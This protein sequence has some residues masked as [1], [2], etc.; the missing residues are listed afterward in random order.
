[1]VILDTTI[2]G[3]Q[4]FRMIDPNIILN[5]LYGYP[6]TIIN[7][8]NLQDLNKFN[9]DKLFC[10]VSIVQNENLVKLISQL[11]NKG[12]KII[13][14]VDDYWE[15]PISHYL[16]RY[17]KQNNLIEKTLSFIQA[18]DLITTTT[19]YLSKEIFKYNKNVAILPNSLN[20]REGQLRIGEIPSEKVRIGWIGGASHLEDIKLFRNIGVFSKL[21]NE[22]IQFLIAGFDI[23]IRNQYGQIEESFEKSV[24]KKYE[25][26][27]TNNYST[28]SDEYKKYLFQLDKH[29]NFHNEYNEP[30]RRVWTKPANKYLKIFNEI[31]IVLIPLT[32]NKFNKY[33]SELKLIEAGFFKKPVVCSD[34]QQYSD[35]INHGENGFLVQEK[36]AHK[37]FT[38]YAKKLTQSKDLRN[39]LGESLYQYCDENFN[40]IKNSKK[41]LEAYNSV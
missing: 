37:D 14:D 13:V 16:Y 1:M 39:E 29:L 21:K 9:D 34:V 28:I 6:I 41:R 11:Q 25:E 33:K 19:K 17:S 18:A 26:I 23:R 3:V 20:P 35:V 24:W 32:N 36:R 4:K 40:L 10:H 38:K 30:Y 15:L 12:V 27:I 2:A 5:E 7:Q 31:D 8:T 22:N